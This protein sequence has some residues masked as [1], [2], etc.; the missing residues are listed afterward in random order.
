MGRG[1]KDPHN[2][3]FLRTFGDVEHARSYLATLLPAKVL[4]HLDLSTLE[5]SPDHFVDEKLRE[6]ESDLLFNV[7]A[8]GA[9]AFLYLLWEHQST[10]AALMSFRLLRYKVRIWDLWLREHPGTETLPPII[11]V[12]LCHAPQGWTAVRSFV[13]LL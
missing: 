13:E 8:K 9:D 7:K 10:V 5:P 12:V 1:G 3:L 11:P 2:A 4:A 6:L